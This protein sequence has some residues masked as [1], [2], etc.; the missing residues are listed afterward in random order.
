M[1]ASSP[2]AIEHGG[3]Q[4]AR[5]DRR[6]EIAHTLGIDGV[7]RASRS[8]GAAADRDR[9]IRGERL[10]HL[11]ALLARDGGK[12]GLVVGAERPGEAEIA[13]GLSRA[14]PRP[15]AAA[16]PRSSSVG[17]PSWLAS[18]PGASATA[19]SATASLVGEDAAADR[20]T[21]RY[22]RLAEQ[23]RAHLGQRQHPG[24]PR[25]PRAATSR[26]AALPAPALD[27]LDPGGEMERRAVRMR[28]DE[29]AMTARAVGIAHA[30]TQRHA[31]PRPR[32][33]HA[34]LSGDDLID[35][36]PSDHNRAARS[37]AR[38]LPAIAPSRL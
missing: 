35:A 5:K 17:Q 32:L 11:G 8:A 6:A 23:E 38:S 31:P 25:S 19:R 15:S 2:N 37:A 30:D 36:A 7:M 28:V 21:A 27:R 14:S 16:P 3:E 12:F 13:V 9:Q 4:P 1:S 24:D 22:Q 26:C 20:E 10:A 33:M 29:G 18:A 34:A